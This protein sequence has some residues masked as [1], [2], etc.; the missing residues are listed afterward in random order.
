MPE[1]TTTLNHGVTLT[2]YFVG[3]ADEVGNP[4]F[5]QQPL[6]QMYA[7]HPFPAFWAPLRL[8]VWHMDHPW[9][10][11]MSAR[12]QYC[13]QD[14]APQTPGWQVADGL[15][16]GDNIDLGIRPDGWQPGDTPAMYRPLLDSAKLSIRKSLSHEVGHYHQGKCRYGQSDDIARHI[17][18]SFRALRPHQAAGD[19]EYEDWAEVFRALMGADDCRGFFSDGK[20]FTPDPELFALMKCAYWLAGNLAGK[21]VSHFTPCNGGVMYQALINGAYRWRWIG[22]D[23][24]S[25]E[26]INGA[27][28]PI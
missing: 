23:G 19:N 13:L 24:R 22:T 10:D 8:H 9:Q 17:T 4:A 21:P 2:R 5:W 11:E 16:V 15:N 26:Y 27:W 14:Y 12:G 18:A 7:Q 25:Q 6:D 28:K 3:A 1:S 20:P